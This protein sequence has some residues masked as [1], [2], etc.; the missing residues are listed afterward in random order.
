LFA[1]AQM[2]LKIANYVGQKLGQTFERRG[3]PMPLMDEWRLMGA[4]LCVIIILKPFNIEKAR[5]K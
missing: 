4:I 5:K 3:T 2:F 1:I